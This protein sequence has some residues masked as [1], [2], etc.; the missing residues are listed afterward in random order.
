VPWSLGFRNTPAQPSTRR[1]RFSCNRTAAHVHLPQ[2]PTDQRR[3]ADQRCP[4]DPQV[5]S[6]RSIYMQIYICSNISTGYPI[7]DGYPVGTGTGPFFYPIGLVGMDI[8][9]RVGYDTGSGIIIPEHNPTRCHPYLLEPSL[10]TL[11]PRNQIIGH[12]IEAS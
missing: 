3:P 7:P 10:P 8:C 11:A 1:W 6:S 9:T 2:R 12:T 4:S 5:L